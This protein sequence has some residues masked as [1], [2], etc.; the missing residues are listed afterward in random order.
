[1]SFGKLSRREKIFY[2]LRK[3][4]M[5]I[6]ATNNYNNFNCSTSSVENEVSI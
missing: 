3:E 6:S 4:N 5:R 2:L 1:M